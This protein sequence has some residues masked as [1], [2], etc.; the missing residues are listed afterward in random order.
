MSAYNTYYNV[1][2]KIKDYFTNNE[3]MV[4][5]IT[6]GDISTIDINKQDLFPLIHYNITNVIP[7]DQIVRFDIVLFAMDIMDISKD[8]I[9]HTSL[10]FYGNDNSID[11]L[12][13]LYIVLMQFRNQLNG[14]Y[15]GYDMY[16][17]GELTMEPFVDRF[18]NGL[19]GYSVQFSVNIPNDL[20]LCQPIETIS[21]YS[22]VLDFSVHPMN[23]INYY[24]DGNFISACYGNNASNIQD[25][26]A[27]LNANPPVQGSAC[28]LTHGNYF[29]NGDG[30]IRLETTQQQYDDLCSG[31]NLTMQVIYD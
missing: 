3:P 17:T 20:E 12:N 14:Q 10:Q 6:Y 25:L 16:M 8:E 22:Q 18:E 28:F 5:K 4:S 27:M 19:A 11:I 21:I 7:E 24:C 2:E 23:S 15:F 26:L 29:D 31:G 13:K 9:E 30:T 1:V